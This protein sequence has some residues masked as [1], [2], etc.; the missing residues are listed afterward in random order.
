MGLAVV[1]ADAGGRFIDWGVLHLSLGNA[2]VILIMLVVF[3][4][5]LVL[6]F[7]AGHEEPP[8]GDRP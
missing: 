6:P 7:P 4:L 5:A 8:D 2:L 3:V 1:A